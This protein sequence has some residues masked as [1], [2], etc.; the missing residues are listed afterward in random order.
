VVCQQ[1]LLRG[2]RLYGMQREISLLLVE[3]IE[4]ESAMLDFNKEKRFRVV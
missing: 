4:Q 1:E 2:G 3:D